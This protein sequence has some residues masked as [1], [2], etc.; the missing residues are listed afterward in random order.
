MLLQQHGFIEHLNKKHF[1]RNE[2]R[3]KK[4][5]HLEKLNLK[6]LIGIFI[7]YGISIVFGATIFLGE[8]VVGQ[9]ARR[10]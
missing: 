7:I 2:S 9:H 10:G 5:E 3:K 6:Y 4:L 8:I 1:Q